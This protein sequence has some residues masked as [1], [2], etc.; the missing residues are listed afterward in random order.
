MAEVEHGIRSKELEEARTSACPLHASSWLV[1]HPLRLVPD[2]REA[3]LVSDVAGRIA[4][5]ATRDR[6]VVRTGEGTAS[7]GSA[8]ATRSSLLALLLI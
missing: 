4:A 5:D 8:V 2:K 7:G 3:P 1:P 6:A